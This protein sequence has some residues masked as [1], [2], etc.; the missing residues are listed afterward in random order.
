MNVSMT[1]AERFT[2]DMATLAVRLGANVQPGQIVAVSSEP[3]KEAMAR[4]VAALDS[5]VQANGRTGWPCPAVSSIV[6]GVWK[7]NGSSPSTS[8]FPP[9]MTMSGL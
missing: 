3:G 5:P 9:S 6:S 8:W 2:T 1:E 4:A 7:E